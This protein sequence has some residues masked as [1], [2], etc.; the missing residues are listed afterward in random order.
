MIGEAIKKSI[1]KREAPD[2][3]SIANPAD[4]KGKDKAPRG[5]E[6]PAGHGQKRDGEDA[7]EP[8]SPACRVA[9][10]TNLQRAM[11]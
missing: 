8:S 5:A 3:A 9:Y 11:A 4:K 6:M 1:V 7:E 2:M 10:D